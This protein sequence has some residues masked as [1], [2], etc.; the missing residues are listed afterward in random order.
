MGLSR[1]LV[2]GALGNVGSH[3]AETLLDWGMEV[4]VADIAPDVLATRFGDRAEPV[5]LNFNDATTFDPALED[6]S[7]VFLIRPPAISRVGPTLNRF[8][9][10]ATSADVETVVFSSVA[11]ADT[12]R[13]VPHHRVEKHL[14]ASGLAWTMLRPGFFAQNIETAYRRDIIEDDRIYVPAGNGKV[15]FIDVRDIAA[16]AALALTD[17]THNMK[18]YH[19]TGPEAF[20]FDQV[21]GMLTEALGRPIT[22]QPATIPGYYQHLKRQGLPTPH[23]L[24]QTILHAG[25]RRGDAEPVTDAA[26]VLLARPPTPL[27]MY[28]GDNVQKWCTTH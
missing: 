21:A 25:L 16:A 22:Y 10:H 8:I 9:D 12:N 6:V 23:A 14:Q 19:L 5:H 15:A 4:R 24:V 18:G 2:T 20:T 1:Y 13:I 28:V 11:G 27:K 7:R 17:T 26:E 3:V